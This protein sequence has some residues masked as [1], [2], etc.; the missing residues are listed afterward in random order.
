[1]SLLS[2]I[3]FLQQES[4]KNGGTESM[5]VDSGV[6]EVLSEKIAPQPLEPLPL[7]SPANVCM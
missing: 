7:I 6:S 3:F 5:D 2:N 4:E 1:M